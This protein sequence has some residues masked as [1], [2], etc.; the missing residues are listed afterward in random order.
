MKATVRGFEVDVPADWAYYDEEFKASV[1]NG[2]GAREQHALLAKLL[3]TLPDVLLPGTDVHRLRVRPGRRQRGQARR[4]PALEAQ[5]AGR[6][7]AALRRL[8]EAAVRRPHFNYD[9]MA[10]H[11]V[12]SVGATAGPLDVPEGDRPTED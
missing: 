7:Q 4:G 1:C 8:L 12:E 10:E 9:A 6:G 2:I 11:A 3:A 5:R